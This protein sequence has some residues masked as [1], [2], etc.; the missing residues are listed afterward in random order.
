MSQLAV[1]FDDHPEAAQ[2]HF[3][4]ARS[5]NAAARYDGAAYHAGYVVECSLKSVLL[6]DRSYDQATGK[7]EVSRLQTWHKKLSKQPF[8]HNL[9]RLLAETV[10]PEGARY[11]PPIE[12]N[13]SVIHW[14]E[15]MRYW[16]PGK[17]D[18]AK[19]TA[20]LSWAEMAVLSVVQMQLDGVL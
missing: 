10:G 12:P 19:A 13:A 16:A 17:V 7:A 6:H 2:K 5:L 9:A 20:Y 4:D 18:R 8:A 1:G 11:L 15:T 3:E 14:T